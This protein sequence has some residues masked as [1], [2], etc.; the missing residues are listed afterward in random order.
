MTPPFTQ[1]RL[2]DVGNSAPALRVG[3]SQQSRFATADLEAER[4]GITHHR[5]AAGSRQG[6]GHRHEQA[7]EVYVVPSGSGRLK[8]DEAI[9]ELRALDAVRVAPP[10]I[11]AFEA[12]PD[13]LEVLAVGARHD[14]DGDLIQDWWAR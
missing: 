11:R 6:F 14:G 7:E 2:A 13:G 8:L 5:F 12:G 3:A 1:I 9:L 4:T 10:V